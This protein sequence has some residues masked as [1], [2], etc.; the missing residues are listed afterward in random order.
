[1]S[2]APRVLILGASGQLGREL[3]GSFS[4]VG[5]I[6]AC[7]RDT[8][9]LANA[10]QVRAAVHD[11][12]PD[13]I[14]NA[15]AY[16]AV[17]RAESEPE[18]AMAVNAR[19]PQ[20][21]AEEAALSGALLVHYSTDYVFDGSKTGPWE[22]TDST[23]PLNVYGA[24]KLTGE[25]A[26]T[27][28]GGKFLIF[29]TSW[30]YGPHGKNFLFTMLRLGRERDQL[31]IVDDQIG[32]P[33]T[34]IELARATRTIVDSILDNQM[35]PPESWSGIYNMTCGGSVSWCGFAKAIFERAGPML[36]GTSP[37]VHG[38]PA[39]A[40]PTPARRPQNS[41]L[42]NE[43]LFARFGVRLAQWQ[44][45]LDQVIRVLAESEKRG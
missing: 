41:V 2:R 11:H 28:A 36:S 42:S 7:D 13:V 27:R 33:T 39:S 26:I 14:L 8:V 1:M 44:D 12:R 31:N 38:I 24:G 37:E 25:Q 15:A 32:A 35:G 43:K 23:N 45:G 9:D 40:Y 4:G 6:I 16:T 17:D 3:Q 19:A 30:V 10:E 20:I 18:L 29:R 34:S 5:E 21:L 22:E